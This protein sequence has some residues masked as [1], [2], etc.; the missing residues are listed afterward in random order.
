M[1]TFLKV[2]GLF[3]AMLF[4]SAMLMTISGAEEGSV[5]HGLCF[6]GSI[7]LCYPLA[8][9]LDAIKALR[10]LCVIMVVMAAANLFVCISSN[11]PAIPYLLMAIGPTV[12]YGLT[13][14]RK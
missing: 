12:V 2:I 13:V 5:L 1:K 8:L 14:F 7:L 4:A 9:K 10:W 3:M 6:S 11:A